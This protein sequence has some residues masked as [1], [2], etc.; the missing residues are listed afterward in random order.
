MCV[1]AGGVADR[2]CR[3]DPDGLRRGLRGAAVSDLT[4][5]DPRDLYHMPHLMAPTVHRIEK[6]IEA[7]AAL[8]RWD[9]LEK[10]VDFLI[11]C[12]GVILGWWDDHVRPNGVHVSRG[13]EKASPAEAKAAIGFDDSRL[14]RWRAARKNLEAYRERV[15]TAARRKAELEAEP[16]RVSPNTGEYEWYTPAEYIAAAREVM[17]G[18]DL[19]PAT[20]EAAQQTVQAAQYYTAK[21]DGLSLSWH[22]R[23]WLNPP[24]SQPLI[25]QFIGKL[26]SEY[27]TGGVEQAIMV[28]NNCTDTEWFHRAVRLASMM[29]FPRGRIRFANPER[30]TGESPL[31]GQTFFYYGGEMRR[32]KDIFGAFGFIVTPLDDPV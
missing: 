27:E 32:F 24:Y 28:T 16:N 30:P 3:D 13:P 23:V 21:D 8:Q 31:Q 22:G 2:D 6:V 26:S 5:L 14:S 12:Q 18:I 10:A 19:D 9:D 1:D 29:C 7:A 11:E 4:T 20:S 25:G 15:R 17:G